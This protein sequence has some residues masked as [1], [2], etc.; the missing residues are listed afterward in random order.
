MSWQYTKDRHLF[1]HR[2]MHVLKQISNVEPKNTHRAL[3]DI[4]A[5]LFK[6]LPLRME[7]EGEK[8]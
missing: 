8:E 6:A 3:D 4:K 1:P 5:N 7:R 2:L